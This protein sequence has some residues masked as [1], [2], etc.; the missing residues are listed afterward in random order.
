MLESQGLTKLK[1][2]AVLLN[3][4]ATFPDGRI[5]ERGANLVVEWVRAA[6][7]ANDELIIDKTSLANGKSRAGRNYALTLIEDLHYKRYCGIA[8]EGVK[9]YLIDGSREITIDYGNGDC[10]RE[11]KVSANGMT[12]TISI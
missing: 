7:P 3:G 5:A 1:Y 12:R 6:I 9:K 4:K 2:R 8:V 10:D 11:I